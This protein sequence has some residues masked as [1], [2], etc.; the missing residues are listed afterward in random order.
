[1]PWSCKRG[2]GSGGV[3]DEG[4]DN[5]DD[6]DCDCDS[7]EDDEEEVVDGFEDVVVDSIEPVPPGGQRRG[8][9]RTPR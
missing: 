4:G 8:T 5:D 7:D 2:L 6:C 9:A 1:M 3:T